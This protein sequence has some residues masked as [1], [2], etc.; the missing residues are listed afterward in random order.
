MLYL[1]LLIILC[2]GWII[3]FF[4]MKKSFSGLI[5]ERNF[6]EKILLHNEEYIKQLKKQIK[7]YEEELSKLNCIFNSVN[8]RLQEL[9]YWRKKSEE[10]N[11]EIHNQLE[12]NKLQEVKLRE[13]TIRFE[14][15]CHVAKE[16]QILL[17]DSEQRLSNQFEKLANRVFKNTNHFIDEQNRQSLKNLIDPIRE[18]LNNFH[19]NI[20]ENFNVESRERHVLTHEIRQ[21]QQLNIKIS[22]EAINLTNA[23]K[24]NNK[25]QGNWGEVVLSNILETSGLREGHEY[26]TQISIL[27]ENTNKVVQPDVIVRLP[28]GKD[29]IIDSKMSLVAYERY[30]NADN[31]ELSRE[32]AIQEHIHSIRNHIKLL[33]RKSY[34]QLHKLRSLDYILM[35]IP[36]EPAFLLAINQQPE[37]I[38]E[39]FQQNI[40]LVSP[41]TLLIALRTINNLWHDEHQN[42]NA[43]RIAIH[44]TKMYDKM[45]LFIDDMSNIGINLEKVQN[46]YRQSMKKLTEGRGN[47]ISQSEIFRKLGVTIKHSINPILVKNAQLEDDIFE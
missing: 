31:D 39:A 20:N 6:T 5:I 17:K 36:I 18:Q 34:Q 11:S 46:S 21:L 7:Q 27:S 16:K 42:H 13:T 22:Q 15:A 4:Y 40:M 45:R 41:T 23:L 28:Q 8:E 26:E 2:F 1:F 43:H 19:N 14:H 32:K 30:F 10:L 3:T 35:F 24:G 12:I 37:L 38:T 9:D 44:A 25:I 33:G 29:I 47:L